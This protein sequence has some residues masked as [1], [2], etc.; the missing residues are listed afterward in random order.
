MGSLALNPVGQDQS[1]EKISLLEDW[2]LARVATSLCCARKCMRLGIWAVAA[3]RPFITAHGR[4]V[5]I[6]EK[7]CGERK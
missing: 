7:E 3:K 1:G 2:K 5:P 4:A 6:K